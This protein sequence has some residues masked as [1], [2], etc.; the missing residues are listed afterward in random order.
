[1]YIDTLLLGRVI[2]PVGV[3]AVAGASFL[4][5]DDAS[6][7]S[8]LDTA[9]ARKLLLARLGRRQNTQCQSTL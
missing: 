6:L 3:G 4:A 9:P 1:M 7:L 2:S 5:I 8:F